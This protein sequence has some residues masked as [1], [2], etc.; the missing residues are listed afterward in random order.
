MGASGPGRRKVALVTGGGS[1]IGRGIALALAKRGVD[2]AIAGRRLDLLEQ[3]ARE[4]SARGVRAVPLQVDLNEEAGRADLVSRV[5]EEFGRLDILVNNAGVM[6]RGGL[7]TRSTLDIISAVAT[8]LLAPIELTRQALP[9]LARRKGAVVLVASA[10]S[11]VPLPYASL[12]SATKAG[13]SAF[14]EAL[15]YELGPLGVRLLL[16]YPPGTDT[17][18]VRGM[19]QA[20][21]VSAFPLASAERVGERIVT[22]LAKG[23]QEVNMGLEARLMPLLYR[24]SPRLVRALYRS[25]RALFER[26]MGG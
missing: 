25:Q 8:N 19:A 10:V 13:L 16:V 4:V 24:I 15:R 2:L 3:V 26:M 17:D 23:R 9:E 14:G 21:G 1:G 6:Q 20:A 12:Y 5:L 7:L 22:S 18:M 11:H